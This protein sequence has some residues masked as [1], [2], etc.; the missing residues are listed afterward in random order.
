MGCFRTPLGQRHNNRIFKYKPTAYNSLPS[1]VGKSRIVK[2]YGLRNGNADLISN[3]YIAKGEIAAVF[4]ETS[5]IRAQDDVDEFDRIAIQQNTIENAQQFEFYVIGNTPENQ[6]HLHIIPSENAELALSMEINPPSDT[7]YKTELYGK[8]RGNMRSTLAANE[9]KTLSYSSPR[10]KR[11][12]KT[13][14]AMASALAKPTW[15]HSYE[16]NGKSNLG[17]PLDTS[18][19]TTQNKGETSL[20]VNTA[21]TSVYVSP[22]S[23]RLCSRNWL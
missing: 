16:P 17:N 19:L 12:R 20:N 13:M 23:K 9:T 1:L 6:C 14:S 11:D 22:S 8:A 5:T 2:D 4:G 7:R 10:C 21:F 3:T 18:I 15:P